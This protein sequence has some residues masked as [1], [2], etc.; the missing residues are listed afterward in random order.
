MQKSTP[1]G[2]AAATCAIVGRATGRRGRAGTAA[3]A[4][5]WRTARRQGWP[6]GRRRRRPLSNRVRLADHPDAV[7]LQHQREGADHA[8]QAQQP[9]DH[10]A[11]VAGDDDGAQHGRSEHGDV[12]EGE[13]VR[14]IAS[15]E[16]RVRYAEVTAMST[17][18]IARVCPASAQATR[19][20]TSAPRRRQ[21]RTDARAARRGLDH[22]G[23]VHGLDPIAHVRQAGPYGVVSRVEPGAVVVDRDHELGAL[24]TQVD[25]DGRGAGVL[26]G[27]LE[28]LETREVGGR[29]DAAAL[30]GEVVG[31]RSRPAPDWCRPPPP[32]RRPVRCR[33]GAAGRCLA[34]AAPG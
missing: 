25:A 28:S 18:V 2:T 24:S 7:G 8:D 32:V 21:R 19:A 1:I 10:V 9:A 30:A 16:S 4:R 6:P 12:D 17:I 33:S 29:L 11:W 26:R 5:R 15:S 22:Q 3:P 14:A 34:R 31:R 13:P 20:R 23:A 27:V